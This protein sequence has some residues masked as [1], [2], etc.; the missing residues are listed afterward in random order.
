[1]SVEHCTLCKIANDY[2]RKWRHT[3]YK[4]QDMNLYLVCINMSFGK[5]SMQ[6]DPTKLSNSN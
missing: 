3:L 2:M 5:P 1:M 4:H 6:Y